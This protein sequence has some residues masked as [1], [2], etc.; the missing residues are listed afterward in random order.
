M[1]VAS[2]FDWRLELSE[3]HGRLGEL[4]VRSEL[5][6]QAG[7]S[8]GC[9]LTTIL[10]RHDLDRQKAAASARRQ[11]PR[12]LRRHWKSWL[13][14]TSCRRATIDTD[15]PG[16]SVSATICRFNASGQRRRRPVDSR[17][18][19]VSTNSEVDTPPLS[20]VIPNHR[21]PARS[22]RGALQRA[23]NVLGG[24]AHSRACETIRTLAGWRCRLPI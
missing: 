2:V 6:R 1:S 13:A 22:T 19:D 24:M 7:F 23:L 21:A 17:P 12:Q 4:F 14:F 20:I 11:F 8:S 18:A 16:S 9:R 3:L 5:R 10:L 15:E